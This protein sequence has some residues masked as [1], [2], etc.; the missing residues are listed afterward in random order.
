MLWIQVLMVALAVSVDSLVVGVSYGFRRVSLP[1]LMMAVVATFSAALKVLAMLLGSA[2]VL[3]FP[4]T[5][6]PLLGGAVLAILGGWFLLGALL[7]SRRE[8]LRSRGNRLLA[9][10]PDQPLLAF[11]LRQLGVVVCVLDDPRAAD[12]DDSQSISPGEAGLLGVALGLDALGVGISA[13]LMQFPVAPT[14]IA[15]G[16]GTMAFLGL[17]TVIG[18]R[19]QRDMPPSVG[20]ALP[21]VILLVLGLMTWLTA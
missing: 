20:R 18:A 7:S 21:G 15:V 5:L 10:W 14:A 13:G 4:P 2:L 9:S 12:V 3:W 11:R 1:A 6:A 19:L 16:V 8:H 17:G